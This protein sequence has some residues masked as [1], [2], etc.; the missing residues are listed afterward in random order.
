[1]MVDMWCME[2][3]TG[4]YMRALTINRGGGQRLVGIYCYECDPRGIERITIASELEVRQMKK[5]G[6]S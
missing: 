1:M 6:N 3:H 2:C 4:E 5:I